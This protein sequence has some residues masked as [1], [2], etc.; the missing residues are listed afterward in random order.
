MKPLMQ[1]ITLT[2]KLIMVFLPGLIA[3]LSAIAQSNQ[4][5]V[6]AW[7]T[8]D[9]G[10]G[11]SSSGPYTL[12]GTIGQPDAA[13]STGGKYELLSGFWPGGPL[14]I[15][16]FEDFAR[17]AE[18]WLKTGTGLPGDID[19][20]GDVDMEDLRRFADYWLSCCP[21]NWQLK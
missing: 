15:V 8:I 21:Y 17:F 1:K 7:R 11:T 3:S 6:L 20:D 2:K 16:E 9:G 19:K 14:C 5:Y 10:G 12:T 18:V 4:S 13:Y